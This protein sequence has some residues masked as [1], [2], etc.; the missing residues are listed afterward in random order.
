M[1]S[2]T[3]QT[4]GKATLQDSPSSTL[5]IYDYERTNF[6]EPSSLASKPDVFRE[7]RRAVPIYGPNDDGVLDS[8]DAA[9]LPSNKANL[10]SFWKHVVIMTE[11]SLQFAESQLSEEEIHELGCHVQRK[12]SQ[13]SPN[14]DTNE[15]KK[16]TI[17]AKL[18]FWA[19]E[20]KLLRSDLVLWRNMRELEAVED[21][22]SDEDGYEPTVDPKSMVLLAN[23]YLMAVDS[24][25]NGTR[26]RSCA[27]SLLNIVWKDLPCPNL[28]GQIFVDNAR[29]IYI[30]L[31]R[32]KLSEHPASYTRADTSGWLVPR[33]DDFS[34]AIED[35]TNLIWYRSQTYLALQ[36]WCTEFSF[37][38]S[39]IS[40]R[41]L[42][43]DL[44]SGALVNEILG[45]PHPTFGF[46]VTESQVSAHYCLAKKD[47]K[48]DVAYTFLTHLQLLG[49]ADLNSFARFYTF[50]CAH[51]SWFLNKV[52]LPFYVNTILQG[53]LKNLVT[54]VR[55]MRPWKNM[56]VKRP[57]EYQS[58]R[59]K[60]KKPRTEDGDKD[61]GASVIYEIVDPRDGALEEVHFAHNG[62]LFP[63]KTR[64]RLLCPDI[65]G[66]CDPRD[67]MQRTA[68]W[69]DNLL[70]FFDDLDDA[71]QFS[72]ISDTASE[73][74]HSD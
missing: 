21:L 28:D 22:Y 64:D 46:S 42:M 37:Q 18:S 30:P 34:F 53:H 32:T 27:E 71:C 3:D 24:A 15:R 19:V 63:P 14:L 16:F 4:S 44:P 59:S 61:E 52:Y 26:I 10:T 69:K 36:L 1:P 23:A 74:G 54:S 35:N 13:L 73:L 29:D 31:A 56:V 6:V 41:Q 48:D 70:L 20:S 58:I 7:W 49:L 2:S 17:D 66:M 12:T 67:G 11:Q 8:L 68:L 38:N 40:Q 43:F 57:A 55:S 25:A 39:S 45:I 47:S 50:L 60:S 51:K 62:V 72:F 33:A 5:G 9:E 65:F